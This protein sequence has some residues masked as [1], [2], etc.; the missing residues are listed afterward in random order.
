MVAV[1]AA[2]FQSQ[3]TASRLFVLNPVKSVEEMM[4]QRDLAFANVA[5]KMVEKGQ[6]PAAYDVRPVSPYDDFSGNSTFTTVNYAPDW[7]VTAAHITDTSGSIAAAG[8]T[9]VTGTMPQDRFLLVYGVS[10]ETPATPSEVALMFKAGANLKNIFLL[11]ELLGYEHP[12]ATSSI[13]PAW[14]PSDSLTIASANVAANP[15]D[16]VLYT[17]WGEPTGNTI[18][19]SNLRA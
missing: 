6:I 7:S 1:S 15:T 19:A 2:P 4:R 10:V 8:N 12:R 9:L 13:Q 14:G 17:F 3:R 11:Q 16:D 18:T 5:T